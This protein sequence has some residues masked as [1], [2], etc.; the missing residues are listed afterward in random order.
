MGNHT[1]GEEERGSEGMG[2]WRGGADGST[3][4][5]YSRVHVNVVGPTTRMQRASL[6]YKLMVAY[7]QR[8]RLC[9]A[10]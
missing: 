4:Q 9:Q 6:L 10:A 1:W 5:P 2:E 3:L 7:A 8:L